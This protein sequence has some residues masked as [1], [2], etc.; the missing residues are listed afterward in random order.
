MT[1]APVTAARG[2]TPVPAGRSSL[3]TS[4]VMLV[5]RHP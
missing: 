4:H 2:L 1:D 3:A 5:T